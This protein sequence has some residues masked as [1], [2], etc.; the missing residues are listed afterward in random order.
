MDDNGPGGRCSLYADEDYGLRVIGAEPS[1]AGGSACQRFSLRK[2]GSETKWD[3]F[4]HSCKFQN[5]DFVNIY[6]HSVGLGPYANLR[7]PPQIAIPVAWSKTDKSCL[8][9]IPNLNMGFGAPYPQRRI[10]QA[11]Y[12]TGTMSARDQEVCER[13]GFIIDV[14]SSLATIASQRPK[15][16]RGLQ[17]KG[18]SS[19]GAK[20][21]SITEIEEWSD[22]R[23]SELQGYRLLPRDH[24]VATGK[25]RVQ[26]V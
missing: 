5:G 13:T 16:T 22:R 24:A 17:D 21:W 15:S 26:F 19:S 8:I 6:C 18:L 10:L 25:F 4:K 2:D 3:P 12:D 7:S 11:E 14:D 9:Q 20:T 23:R 1:I